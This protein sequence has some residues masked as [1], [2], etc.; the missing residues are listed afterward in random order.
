MEEK[1]SLFTKIKE[2]FTKKKVIILIAVLAVAALAVPR[3]LPMVMIKTQGGSNNPFQNV[4]TRTTVLRKQVLNDSVSVTGTVQSTQTVNVTVTLTGYTVSEILVQEGD[5]VEEG[6]VIARLDTG[7][8]LEKIQ[9]T[10]DKLAKNVDS[11]QQAYTEAEDAQT[12]AYNQC[13][14]QETVLNDAKT[15]EATSKTRYDI[16]LNAIS[17]QQSEYDAAVEAD[18][19]ANDTNNQLIAAKNEAATVAEKALNTYKKAQDVTKAAQDAYDNALATDTEESEN[20]VDLE[21]LQVELTAAQAAEATAKSDYDVAA[22]KL[23]DVSNKQ[24]TTQANYDSAKATKAT[25]LENLNTAKA[26]ANFTEIENEY[27][28]AV[29]AR[30]TARSTLDS[31]QKTYTNAVNTF[32]KAK[33]NLENANT[34]D[35]LEDLYEK[36]NNCTIKANASGTITQVNTQVGSVASGTLAVIQD[37]D[38]LKISTSFRE[39]DVQKLEIGM[40]CIIT[41]D[42]N[43]KQLSGYVSQISPVASSGGMGGSS[44][45]SFSGEIT[46]NGTDHGLLIGMNAAAEVVITQVT[47]AYVVPFDAVGTNEN[48]EKVVYVQNNGEFTPVVVTTGME[49]DYYIEI[50]SDQ[51]SEGMVIRSSANADESESVVFTEDGEATEEGGFGGMG[52][53]GGFSGGMPSGGNFP[54]GGGMPSGMPSGGNRPS[55]GNFPSGG[56]MPGGRG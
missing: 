26:T 49:T 43:D 31:L 19:K 6:D 24:A 41:S 16:A 28:R 35:E 17:L 21:Q 12:K 13:I 2:K 56:G 46:I 36:Y 50:T 8:L 11:A 10:K 3:I 9:E 5:R 52:M 38:N 20:T 45:V 40:N 18:A 37:T 27:N 39:Y 4:G 47:D 7:D 14:D 54:S 55:G 29:K 34:S 42:A 33:E 1:K 32:E 53:M 22:A 30:T 23:S 25:A 15:A 44:D 51:L 48:G